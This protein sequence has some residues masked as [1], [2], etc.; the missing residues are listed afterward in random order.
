M[1]EYSKDMTQGSS[2]RDTNDTAFPLYYHYYHY[3]YY[4][5]YYYYYYY[6]FFLI[7][8][9]NIY[10]L[11]LALFWRI[12]SDVYNSSLYC[13]IYVI[14]FYMTVLPFYLINIWIV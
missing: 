6:Y 9:H 8:S 11:N 2:A 5:Y 10:S 13:F 1:F 4:H 12:K 14:F 7:Q 3:Y